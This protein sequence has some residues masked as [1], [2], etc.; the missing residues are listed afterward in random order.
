MGKLALF[1]LLL[2]PQDRV[3]VPDADAQR[4]AEKVVREVFGDPAKKPAA[5]RITL[6]RRLL[7]QVM[8]TKDDPASQYVMLRE[9]RDLA[10]R[11][12]DAATAL[13]AVDE[14]ARR[15]Q[16]DPVQE[17]LAALS[18]AV[19]D[20]R[21]DV[22]KPAAEAYLK[23]ADDA[24][25]MG[26]AEGA[27]K[28]AAGAAATARKAKDVA[29]VTRAD[30]K[31]RETGDL[32]AKVARV[33]K[34]REVLAATPADPAANLDVGE[35]ECFL[36]GNWEA[37]LPLL[38]KGSEE[39]LR[40]LAQQDLA[41]PAAPQDRIVLA[42]AWWERGEKESGVARQKIQQRAG[43]WYALAAVDA[44]GLWRVRV[45]RRLQELGQAVPLAPGKE[46]EGLVGWW[47][48]DDG[49]GTKLQDSSGQNRHGSLFG[50]SEWE[51][52]RV[53]QAL[54]FRGNQPRASVPSDEALR[55]T[56]DM[57]VAAWFFLESRSTDWV[58]LVGKGA[59]D[60]R[61][62]GLW[63]EQPPGNRILFQMGESPATHTNV[64][65]SGTSEVGK[66]CH[67]AGVVKDATLTLYV[68][69]KMSSSQP[70][71]KVPPTSTDPLTLGAAGFHG[72]LF[73]LLDDV[74][75][76]NRALSDQEIEQLA[77]PK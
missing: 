67:L 24:A 33:K 14:M 41:A 76:Y 1:A 7:Q 56:G 77:N 71:V 12:G 66:W 61:N 23:L 18:L 75:L 5:E 8:E 44:K 59:P 19:Q 36:R 13:K 27:E 72:G 63:L 45:E 2:V 21:P 55:L 73:G 25:V 6:S 42:D 65:A 37:G 29:L 40:S 54:R 52:G 11:A 15:F 30:A 20:G 57:T 39:A 35:F 53:N 9:S 64:F 26:D 68:N 28:A 17:K 32:K 4:K 62:Y 22:M 58:R 43:H 31:V 50:E 38:A 10:A 51:K 49:S 60:T 47:K 3:P 69:G 70:R 16:I 46:L 34:A 48:L 74:R